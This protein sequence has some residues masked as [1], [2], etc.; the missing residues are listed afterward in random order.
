MLKLRKYLTPFRVPLIIS[1]VL[2]ALKSL[3]DLY[4]QD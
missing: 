1:M 4:L 3:S 2:L